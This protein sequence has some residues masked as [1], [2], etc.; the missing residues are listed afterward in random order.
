MLVIFP[1]CS[2]FRFQVSQGKIIDPPWRPSI[3]GMIRRTKATVVPVYFEGMNTLLF[4]ILGILKPR[5]RMFLLPREIIHQTG[6]TFKLKIE[7]PISY[8]NLFEQKLQS[9][10]EIINYL[11][12]RTYHLAHRI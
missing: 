1:A 8:E 11:R 4:G 9:D 5:L 6:K 3:A 12:Q 7:Q 2:V 10:V